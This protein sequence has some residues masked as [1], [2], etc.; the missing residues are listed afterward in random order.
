[1]ENII[2]VAGNW[3]TRASPQILI[4]RL[5]AKVSAP[6]IVQNVMRYHEATDATMTEAS[7]ILEQSEPIAKKVQQHLHF[8]FVCRVAQVQPVSVNYFANSDQRFGNSLTIRP[9]YTNREFRCKKF[10]RD[11]GEPGDSLEPVL[12]ST[13]ALSSQ[14]VS[15]FCPTANSQF[16]ASICRFR[17]EERNQPRG[18]DERLPHVID[19]QT[20]LGVLPK[21]VILGERVPF[22]I[23][24]V[25]HE[26]SEKS[27]HRGIPAE[28]EQV[29]TR[30]GNIFELASGMN[31]HKVANRGCWS[32]FQCEAAIGNC[33]FRAVRAS[34]LGRRNLQLLLKEIK[35]RFWGLNLRGQFLI[36]ARFFRRKGTYLAFIGS[37]PIRELYSMLLAK[38][39][40]AHFQFEAE[41]DDY[42]HDTSSRFTARFLWQEYFRGRGKIPE[43]APGRINNQV[44]GYR[45]N[46]WLIK[47][48]IKEPGWQSAASSL[49]QGHQRRFMVAAR[50]AIK[51]T[52]RLNT[53]SGKY[54]PRPFFLILL[55]PSIDQYNSG[56]KM[57]KNPKKHDEIILTEMKK[58]KDDEH[59]PARE[60]G[61][62]EAVEFTDPR[63][64]SHTADPDLNEV[65]SDEFLRKVDVGIGLFYAPSSQHP[66]NAPPQLISID[67]GCHHLSGW[68]RG[69]GQREKA[70]R[71]PRG[72]NTSHLAPEEIPGAQLML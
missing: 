38:F 9:Q 42:F 26:I 21:N 11:S 36:K 25:V 37:W 15:M 2:V 22:S 52:H 39:D 72:N 50:G 5:N 10:P 14:R 45:Y 60:H 34:D 35:P 43:A 44:L 47:I 19:V 4:C 17:P 31:S 62:D 58:K 63:L 33:R 30:L 64:T 41:D 1:M 61:D 20:N 69:A 56:L 40:E 68:L 71:A 66:N 27:A 46:A 67:P 16:A 24:E 6:C 57:L 53:S 55:R 8:K 13:N 48:G 49:N 65:I 29:R 28:N 51:R 59:L 7:P 12:Q 32:G 70:T 54:C 23:R 3:A 18:I